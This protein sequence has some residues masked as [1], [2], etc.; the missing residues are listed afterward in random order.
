MIAFAY[1][2]TGPKR[3]ALYTALAIGMVENIRAVMPDQEILMVTDDKTPPIKGINKILRIERNM[4]LMTWRLKCHQ[5]AHSFGDEIVFT[6]PDVRFRSNIMDDF[7]RSVDIA[8]TT[9]EFDVFINNEKLNSPFTLG[10]TFS[11]SAEFWR[12]AKLFCQTM[13]EEDQ[14]W[15][16]DMLSIAHVIGTEKFNV[17]Q[18]DGS[19]YNHV[20]NDPHADT[21][22]KVLHYKGKRKS[23]LFPVAVEE[24]A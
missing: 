17:V 22:A 6:E 12:E 16:G 21:D 7:D 11:R 20:V 14:G 10:M 4:P 13:S 19:I 24:A 9:R 23:F 15:F 8:V 1:C 5:L 18:M 3:E 2:N